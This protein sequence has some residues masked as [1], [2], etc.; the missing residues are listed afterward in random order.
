MLTKE[1]GPSQYAANAS[2]MQIFLQLL[3]IVTDPSAVHSRKQYRQGQANHW[4]LY[5]YILKLFI[6]VH[7]SLQQIEQGNHGLQGH[8]YVDVSIW[9]K[10]ANVLVFPIKFSVDDL[11]NSG[12]FVAGTSDNVFVVYRYV[13]A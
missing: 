9:R 12:F 8:P 6:H 10:T 11:I 5:I 2:S 3:F 1:A 4:S 13:T 7:V